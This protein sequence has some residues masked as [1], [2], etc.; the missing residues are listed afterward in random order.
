MA[1]ANAVDVP[2]CSVTGS[3]VTLTATTSSGTVTLTF[4]TTAPVATFAPPRNGWKGAGAAVLALLVF[5]GIPSRRRSWCTLAGLVAAAF[6]LLSISACGS[7]NTSGNSNPG[8]TAG[9]YTYT[10]TGTGT[11]AP[12]ST[13]ATTVTLTVN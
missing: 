8:T 9:T 12:N 11:P 1:P 6:V 5:F 10:V 7:S 4:T 2:G 3:P 13:P